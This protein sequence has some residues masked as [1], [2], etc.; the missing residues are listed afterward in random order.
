MNILIPRLNGLAIENER[1]W[2]CGRPSAEQ[3]A[4]WTAARDANLAGIEAAV[5]GSPSAASTPPRRR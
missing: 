1:T 5:S 4:L 2:F 3:A